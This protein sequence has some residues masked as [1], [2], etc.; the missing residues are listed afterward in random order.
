VSNLT[1]KSRFGVSSSFPKWIARNFNAVE[2]AR[3]AFTV[4]DEHIRRSSKYK[5]T[6]NMTCFKGTPLDGCSSLGLLVIL[7]VAIG[8]QNCRKEVQAA[9]LGFLRKVLKHLIYSIDFNLQIDDGFQVEIKQGAVGVVALKAALD[10]CDMRR[11]FGAYLLILHAVH[12]H[13]DPQAFV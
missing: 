3:A 9:F 4:R 5:G 13:L 11:R 8:H 6:V 2:T 1:D 12:T 7:H 10:R